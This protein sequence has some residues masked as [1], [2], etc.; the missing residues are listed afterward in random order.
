MK[1]FHKATLGMVFAI[2][3]VLIMII[4]DSDIKDNTLPIGEQ[5]GKDLVTNNNSFIDVP[6]NQP[7][8]IS[9]ALAVKM[10]ALVKEEKDSITIRD[11]EIEFA[12]S[13]KTDWFDKYFN[14]AIVDEW[15]KPEGTSLNPL[16]PLTNAEALTLAHNLKLDLE[17]NQVVLAGKDDDP[18]PYQEWIKL[19]NL[20]INQLAQD[21]SVTEKI[22]YV[23]ATPTISTELGGWEL[24]TDY[25]KYGFEGITIDG[26]MNKE[27]KVITK[28]QEILY[29]KE[30]VDEQPILTNAYMISINEETNEVE[31]FMGGVT[32]KISIDNKIKLESKKGFIADI[33]IRGNTLTSIKEKNKMTKGVISKITDE[34]VEIKDIGKMKLSQDIKFYDVLQRPAFTNYKAIIVGYDTATFVLDENQVVA[35]VIREKAKIDHIRVVITTTGFKEVYHGNVILSSIGPY[36]LQFGEKVETIGAGKETDISQLN[37]EI[38]DRVVF[39]PDEGRKIK[40][41]SVKRGANSQI[42]P[43]Y[44]GMIEVERVDEGYLIINEVDF[45]EY[46]YGVVPS[47]MPTSYGLEAAKV[48]A[49]CARSYAYNQIYSNRFCEYGAHVDDST[50]SQVYNNTLETETAIQAVNDTKGQLLAY[51]GNVISTNFFSTSCGMTADGGDVWANY[52]TKEFPTTTAPY[53]TSAYQN[54]KGSITD[55]LSKEDNF[56]RFIMNKKQPSFDGDYPWYRWSTQMTAKQIEATINKS[57][58][59]RYDVQPKLI[60]TLDDKDIFRSREVN[61]IGELIDLWIFSR[62]DSGIITEMVVQGSKGVYKISTEY[63]IR[64]LIAPI[65]YIEGSES[66]I[67]T[68]NDGNTSKDMSL[69]PS[70]FY[71]M[72]KKYNDKNQLESVT[73]YGGG[74]GHGAGMSQNGAK[75]M[76]DLGYNYE[77][78][79]KHYY[80]GTELITL[81]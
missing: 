19:F 73:F 34:E 33:Q 69:M 41:L 71:I 56:K 63:N 5:N 35:A 38:G 43:E 51:E 27:I 80:K 70:A 52:L 67:I 68:K 75:T 57:I 28:G 1:N 2:I 26:C 23:F 48:Q 4:L 25:G 76:V 72:E 44:R 36:Q 46:L 40:L 6:F 31:V 24:A 37:L 7:Q 3:V 39:T 79:L 9:K 13:K 32:R 58:S 30:I 21:N 10:I 12:D 55:D 53:L 42:N 8:I 77:E 22:L 20:Y 29:V 66:V 16:D 54:D 62:G 17:N 50:S 65:N 49:V 47:E 60:K 15:Y 64:A 78:V 14:A 11:R 61:D 81:E 59:K 45:E 74:Y 18:I